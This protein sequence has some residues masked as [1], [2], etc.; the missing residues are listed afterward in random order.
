MPKM[1]INEAMVLGKAVRGRLGELSSLRSQVATRDIFYGSGGKEKVVE[2]QYD[3]KILDK[4]CVV[5]EN[6][7]LVL[8]S[9]IKQ[10]NAVTTIEIDTDVEK[11]LA[12]IE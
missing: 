5:I 4:K 3:V 2:P 6:F 11:L 7:L 9:K 8:D 12:P 10:S 1:T